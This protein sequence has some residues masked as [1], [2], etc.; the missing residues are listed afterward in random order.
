MSSTG[1]VISFD[2]AR[3]YGFIHP[4]GGRHDICVHVS[5]VERSHLSTLQPG[6]AIEYDIA[7]NRAGTL[8]AINLKLLS[9]G[10]PADRR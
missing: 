9:A 4:A 2:P 1:T 3:G 6:Q 7:C 10:L 5:A 8:M